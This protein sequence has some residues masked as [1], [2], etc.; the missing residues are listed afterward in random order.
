[1]LRSNQVITK[2]QQKHRRLQQQMERYIILYYP[3][4]L[5]SHFVYLRLNREILSKKNEVKLLSEKLINRKQD[6]TVGL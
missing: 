1:M 6:F 5:L 4:K 2:A 3:Y